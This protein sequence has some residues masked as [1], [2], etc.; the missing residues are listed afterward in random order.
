M[1]LNRQIINLIL[2]LNDTGQAVEL[3]FTEKDEEEIL[4]GSNVKLLTGITTIFDNG[5]NQK[6]KFH[7]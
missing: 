1:D 3:N 2:R 7:E 4:K 5:M 6:N